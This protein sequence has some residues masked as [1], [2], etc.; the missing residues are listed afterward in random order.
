MLPSLTATDIYTSVADDYVLGPL[1]VC[2]CAC[3][4]PDIYSCIFAE[5][6]AD[7]RHILPAVKN[8]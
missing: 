7:T 2:L 6:T 4:K 8:D 3:S 5:F 1:Y